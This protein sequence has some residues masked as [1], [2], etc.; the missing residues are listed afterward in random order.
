MDEHHCHCHAQIRCYWLVTLVVQTTHIRCT[1]RRIVC[2]V[3]AGID[4]AFASMAAMRGCAAALAISSVPFPIACLGGCEDGKVF[5]IVHYSSDGDFVDDAMHDED[6]D[7]RME[8]NRACREE[9]ENDVFTKCVKTL[10]GFYI[11]NIS[12]LELS[13]DWIMRYCQCWFF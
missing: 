11:L 12:A 10:A 6:S 2:T 5:T 9:L 8:L 3:P 13:L 4:D 1:Y 7:E